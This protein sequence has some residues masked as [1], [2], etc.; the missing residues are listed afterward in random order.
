MLI[1]ANVL[2]REMSI[3]FG[4]EIVY[5]GDTLVSDGVRISESD[6]IDYI[7][8]AV[9]QILLVRPDAN[10]VL[11]SVAL[12]EGTKQ[13]I[14][15]DGHCFIDIT[16]NM[17]EDGETPGKAIYGAD[18]ETMDQMNPNWHTATVGTVVKNYMFDKK[19]PRIYFV[20]PPIGEVTDVYVEL[21]YS[22]IPDAIDQSSDY[23]PLTE[24][25][26][27]PIKDWALSLAFSMDAD[28]GANSTLG[29]KHQELFYR[30]LG[31]EFDSSSMI[32]P[33]ST[34]GT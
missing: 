2:I 33:E 16:R 31:I 6:W 15:D 32:M 7:N 30:E 4:D 14:P 23:M 10:A 20:S 21:V 13:K 5:T 26:F 9:L 22:E 27:T 34:E 19:F 1:K 3:R 18:R 29:D 24:T 8:Q 17:G 11:K 28:S 25:Y 12:I